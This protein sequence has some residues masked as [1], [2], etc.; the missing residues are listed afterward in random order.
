MRRLRKV[1]LIGAVLAI[2]LCGQSRSQ[3][4][5]ACP[6][7]TQEPAAAAAPPTAGAAARRSAAAQAP[8]HGA[9]RPG[10][11]I[12]LIGTNDLPSGGRGRPPELVAEGIRANLVYLRQHL[13]NARILLLGLYPREDLPR[14]RP[15]IPQ[16]NQLIQACGDD[17]AVVY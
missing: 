14:L 9:A 17:H 3:A 11:V 2:P 15:L 10:G 5:L 1:T 7:F 8:A 12:V 13:A 16:V 6:H 4:Q